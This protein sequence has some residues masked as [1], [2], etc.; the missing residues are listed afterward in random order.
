MNILRWFRFCALSVLALGI[1]VLGGLAFAADHLSG[2]VLTGGAPLAKSTVALWEA[3]ANAPKKLSETKSNDDGRFDVRYDGGHGDAILYLV[4]TGGDNPAIVL[5]AVLGNRPP[6]KVVVN[7]LTPVA[8]AFT[9]AQFINGGAISGLRRILGNWL[10][11]SIGRAP[12]A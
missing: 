3:S 10:T 5:L 1:T 8:S 4:A 9:A 7:E 12:L 11:L 6:E 2:Q